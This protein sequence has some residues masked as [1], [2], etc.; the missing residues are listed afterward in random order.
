MR[1]NQ[2]DFINTYIFQKITFIIF[3]I[4]VQFLRCLPDFSLTVLN[5]VSLLDHKSNLQPT[6]GSLYPSKGPKILSTSRLHDLRYKYWYE[7]P[8]WLKMIMVTKN[9]FSPYKCLFVTTQK[10][11]RISFNDLLYPALLVFCRLQ[12]SW[13][14]FP[15]VP[16]NLKILIQSVGLFRKSM[17]ILKVNNL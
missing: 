12:A 10:I 15:T 1:H 8:K 14:I 7:L 9:E 13:S 4:L 16:E 2:S 3:L 11:M 5:I 17:G 6:P